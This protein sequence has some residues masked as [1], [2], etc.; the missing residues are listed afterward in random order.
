MSD[1]CKSFKTWSLFAIG[2]LI[3]VKV[4]LEFSVLFSL[5][6]YIFYVTCGFPI[7]V[8]HVITLITSKYSMISQKNLSK[9]DYPFFLCLYLA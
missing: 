4:G 6:R 8:S 5:S 3:R 7:S 1:M 2:I 9:S